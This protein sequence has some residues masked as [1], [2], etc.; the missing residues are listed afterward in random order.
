MSVN[1]DRSP[2]VNNECEASLRLY[3][4]GVDFMIHKTHKRAMILDLK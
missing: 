2:D 1:H 3:K 4:I